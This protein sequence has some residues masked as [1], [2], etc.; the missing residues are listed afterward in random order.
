MLD[1]VIHKLQIAY[2]LSVLPINSGVQ[3]CDR[4]LAPRDQ[5][6]AVRECFLHFI[7]YQQECYCIWQTL[8]RMRALLKNFA[9]Y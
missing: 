3:K 6:L 1:C 9:R 4:A 7:L 2:H 8:Y 5:K